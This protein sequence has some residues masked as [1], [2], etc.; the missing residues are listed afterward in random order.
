[1]SIT[2]LQSAILYVTATGGKIQSMPD[3][4]APAAVTVRPLKKKT[5][6]VQNEWICCAEREDE[7]KMTGEDDEGSEVHMQ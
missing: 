7:Q 2:S 3:H 4:S 5:S 1:M 6:S